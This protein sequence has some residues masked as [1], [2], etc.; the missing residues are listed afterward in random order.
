MTTYVYET[1]PQK[2]GAEPRRF[3]MRQSMTDAPLTAIPKPASR[4]DG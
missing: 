4:C 2:P 3:E 1:V